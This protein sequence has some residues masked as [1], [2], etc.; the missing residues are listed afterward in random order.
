MET[1]K[2]RFV[3]LIDNGHGKDT[4]GKR[5][6]VEPGYPQGGRLLEYKYARCLLYTSD[7]ADEL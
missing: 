2:S 7:A 4:K 1:K 3:I 6:P 5:S